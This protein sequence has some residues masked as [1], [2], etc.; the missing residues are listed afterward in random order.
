MVLPSP[1]R[2]VFLDKDGT[3]IEDVPYNVDPQKI[4]L[5]PGAVRGAAAAPH[6][7]VPGDRRVE[8][9]GRR[10]RLLREATVAAVERRLRELLAE[11]G[12]RWRASTTAR[13][14]H[15]ARWPGTPS[16]ATCRKPAPGMLVR[17]AADHGID[18]TRSWLV[19]DTLD[20]VEAGHAA[21]CTTILLDRGHEQVWGGTPARRPHHTAA[22][23]AAA[24]AIIA[25]PE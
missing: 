18:L 7:G 13:T 12:C 11:V 15:R 16:P 9:V 14:T 5:T 17:A 22:D 4:L 24:A 6:G 2:A 23:L 19:G 21:G 1:D 20:D 10:P 3:L 8:P 25:A